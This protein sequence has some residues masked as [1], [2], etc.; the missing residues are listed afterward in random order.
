V[1]GPQFTAAEVRLL[2]RMVGEGHE[3]V[4]CAIVLNRT[5]RSVTDKAK[6]EGKP[7]GR[8]VGANGVFVRFSLGKEEHA[9]LCAV[10]HELETHPNKLA[11]IILNICAQ[12]NKWAELL[13][14]SD[15]DA[16]SADAG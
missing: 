16:G 11:R 6:R 7:F 10:A 9:T 8:G 5:V 2:L 13:K 1:P 14:L 12:Q 4:S 15:E 3:P